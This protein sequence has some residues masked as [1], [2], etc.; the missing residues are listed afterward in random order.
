MTF[1]FE[2][3]PLTFVDITGRTCTILFLAGSFLGYIIIYLFAVLMLLSC[4]FN[5]YIIRC[6]SKM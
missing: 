2:F 4:V 3:N 6:D 1:T 5:A